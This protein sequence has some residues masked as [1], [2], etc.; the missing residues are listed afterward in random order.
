MLAAIGTAHESIYLEMYIFENDTIGYDFLEELERKAREGVRVIVILDAFGSFGLPAVRIQ[1]LREAGAEVLFF[2]YWFRRTHRKI[3][4]TDETTAFLGGVNI[5]HRF[6]RWSDLQVRVSGK[7]VEHVL[8]SFARVYHECGGKDPAL[9]G[10]LQPRLLK[11]ARLWFIEHGIGRKRTMLRK[12]YEKHIDGAERSIVLVTP[13]LLPHRWLISCLHRALTRGVEVTIITPSKTDYRMLDRINYY[14]I[15]LFNK[16]G[17]VCL[18]SREMNH[19]KV[20]LIDERL[21]TIGS[22]NLDALSF[23][24]NIEAGVFFD[25]ARMIRDLLSIIKKWK[26]HSILFAATTHPPHWYDLTL[27]LF[28]RLFQRTF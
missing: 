22:Q 5:A 16:L 20:M 23:E 12:H 28:L 7:V 21:G 19:A 1:Q 17:A 4:I 6:A 14:Y 26:Q 10:S 2:T 9:T 27:A 13:Y 11:K 8:H 15:A 25:N 24:W 3:L 18:L